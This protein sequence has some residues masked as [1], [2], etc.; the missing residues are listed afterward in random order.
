MINSTTLVYSPHNISLN[1]GVG[2]D[3]TNPIASIN[4]KLDNSV[5][6]DTEYSDGIVVLPIGVKPIIEPA[7]FDLQA[8]SRTRLSV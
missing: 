3:S 4:R 6:T 8:K 2:N 7:E 5:L 1:I